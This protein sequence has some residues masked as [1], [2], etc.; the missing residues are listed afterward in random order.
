VS[1]DV[2]PEL[3]DRADRLL[4]EEGIVNVKLNTA[5]G[6]MGIASTLPFDRIV[7]WA[8][9]DVLP[10]YWVEQ[11]CPG[12]LIVAPIQIHPLATAT[13]I[14]RLRVSSPEKIVGEKI[15]RGGFVPLTSEPL[16]HWLGPAE[17][18]DIIRMEEE[19]PIAWASAEWLKD[20]KEKAHKEQ[21]LQLLMNISP[22]QNPLQPDEDSEAL[23]AYLLAT[24]PEGLTT[25]YTETFGPCIG[26]SYPD[27]LA[28][29]SLFDQNYGEAGESRAAETLASWIQAWRISQCPGFEQ[30]RPTIEYAQNG[31]KVS[32]TI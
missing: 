27:S 19:E 11:I 24:N 22:R 15:I 29:L 30:L 12:G 2:D 28:L 31:W 14:V 23:W 21:T 8:T 26:C 18:A 25:A 3:I 32:V 6:R 4:K 13:A 16:Y 20:K 5:D 7:A 9:A 17:K 1:L 10:K